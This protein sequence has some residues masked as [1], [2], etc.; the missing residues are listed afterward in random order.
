MQL[1]PES[2]KIISNLGYVS[3]AEGNKE[4]ARKYFSIVL[5]L[6]PKDRIAAAEL[7]KLEK[8]PS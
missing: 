7:L 8:D 4:D 3:L 1:E 2:T 6:D 5:E